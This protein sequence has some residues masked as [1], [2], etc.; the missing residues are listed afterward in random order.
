MD[1]LDDWNPDGVFLEMPTEIP[2]RQLT[3]FMVGASVLRCFLKWFAQL[4]W[5]HEDTVSGGISYYKLMF[6]FA[7][8]RKCSLPQMVKKV[9]RPQYADPFKTLLQNSFL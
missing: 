2:P 4:K 8:V 9:T 6:N 5:P 3:A 7:G 1:Q